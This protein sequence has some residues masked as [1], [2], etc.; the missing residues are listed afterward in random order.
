MSL[1]I[2]LKGDMLG[3]GR[4]RRA[5]ASGAEYSANAGVGSG[6][7]SGAWLAA[8]ANAVRI[9]SRGSDIG[10]GTA[11]SWGIAAD[12]LLM[13]AAT[14]GTVACGAAGV[15]TA[16]VAVADSVA[17]VSDVAA[18]STFAAGALGAGFTGGSGIAAIT[19]SARPN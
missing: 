14:A 16:S 10:S 15:V 1:A 19:S 12:A 4:R 9:S 11:T 8:A 2:D 13:L 5:L 7:V 17:A 3:P 18:A 6:L